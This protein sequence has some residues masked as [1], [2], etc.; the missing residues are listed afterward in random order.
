VEHTFLESGSGAR[1]FVHFETD[2]GSEAKPENFGHWEVSVG[3]STAIGH[4]ISLCEGKKRTR[5]LFFGS[6]LAD[7][8]RRSEERSP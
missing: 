3:K 2:H 5:R 1:E 8:G 7:S 4:L 6:G